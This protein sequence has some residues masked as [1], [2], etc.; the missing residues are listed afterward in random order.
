MGGFQFHSA[1]LLAVPEVTPALVVGVEAA[2]DGAVEPLH[3]LWEVAEG[4]GH[5]QVE[6]VRENADGMDLYSSE[7]GRD[8]E[9]VAKNGIDKRSRKEEEAALEATP[10]EEI[11]GTWQNASRFGQSH[12]LHVER[13]QGGLR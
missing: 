10:S 11:G 6:M 5:N 13:E 4:I 12:L 7:G 1:V 3:E 8:R 2:G 9:A